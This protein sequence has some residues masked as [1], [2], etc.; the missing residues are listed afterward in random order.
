MTE[1]VGANSPPGSVLIVKPS[2]LGDLVTALPVLRGLRRTFPK[3][4]IAW[5]V[6]K[7]FAPMLS[8]EDDLD[9]VILFDRPLL[10]GVWRSAR[11]VAALAALMRRLGS[12]RFDWAL[13][14]QGL[15]RSGFF[16]AVTRARLRAGFADA[17]EG[18]G[19]FYTHRIQVEATHTVERNLA[20][21][22]R[23]GIDARAEDMHLTVPPEGRQFAGA[24]C[25]GHGFSPGGFLVCVPSTRWPTKQYPVRPWG[26]C[27]SQL[28]GRLPGVVVGGAGDVQR[29]RAVVEGAP[30]GVIDMG[31]R[32]GLVQLV[33]LIAAARGVL[34]SDSAAKF[35]ASAVGVD[36]VT[37]MGP[38]RSE[39]TGPYRLGRTVLAGVPCQGCLKRR[40][41]HVTCMEAIPPDEVV[42][43]VDAM[44]A[45]GG[46]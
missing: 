33:G 14:L 35:I 39:R 2:S 45:E 26:R 21:A 13:D 20:L 38:T 12:E 7:A 10:G 40:C 29:C 17:R 15:W 25:R 31:G 11:A 43:A 44:L 3:A 46:G 16:T 18:A 27:R 22:R 37:L 34:C 1:S 8:G 24:F 41:S 9:E 19:V 30:G 42:L 6:A 4:R 28:A 36:S 23:L 32:T 5:F